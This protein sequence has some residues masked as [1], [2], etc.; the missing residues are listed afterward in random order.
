MRIQWNKAGFKEI[1]YS[2][3][4]A[5]MLEAEAEKIADRA[6]SMGEGQYEVG[7]RPG[8]AR[9]QGRWRASVV[10][11]DYKAMRETARND[12]LRKALG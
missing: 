11:A 9:P 8:Q 2:S 12:V 6:R 5:A 7:S 3:E 1:R 4:V 10:T